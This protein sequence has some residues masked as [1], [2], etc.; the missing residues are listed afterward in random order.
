VPAMKYLSLAE[1][2]L[3][4][5]GKLMNKKAETVD[6]MQALEAQGLSRRAIAKE[7]NCTP[8]YVTQMLGA[9]RSYKRRQATQD[10]LVVAEGQ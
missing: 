10:P 9:K 8:P 6:R 2:Y 7:M 3:S 5:K 1:S 4:L